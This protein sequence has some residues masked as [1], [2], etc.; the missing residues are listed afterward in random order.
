MGPGTDTSFS[1]N[2]KSLSA[3]G[4]ARANAPPL[5][6]PLRVAAAEPILRL[7]TDLVCAAIEAASDPEEVADWITSV[8]R[9]AMAGDRGALR[10]LTSMLEVRLSG[11]ELLRRALGLGQLLRACRR[12]A[13][14]A[15]APPGTKELVQAARATMSR[16]GV[17]PHAMHTPETAKELRQRT[18]KLLDALVDH[19]LQPSELAWLTE[20][21]ELEMRA[22]ALLL[23]ALAER[24]GACDGR[25]IARL[26]P[27]LSKHEERLRDTRSLLVKLPAPRELVRRTPVLLGR[28]EDKGFDSVVRELAQRPEGADAARAFVLATW[29]APLGPE[30][31]FFAG[32]VRLVADRLR[33]PIDPAHAVL[34]A[35][36]ARRDAGLALELTPPEVR[37]T[38]ALWEA[39]GAEGRSG[40]FVLEFEPARHDRLL[41]DDLIPELEA[42]GKPRPVD[43][44][45]MVLSN[46]G[47]EHVVCGLLQSPK[48]SG[49]PGLVEQIVIRT[50]SIK[51]LLEV[52]NRRDLHSGAANRNVPR[53]LLWHPG[54]VPVSAL[55]KF[56]HVRFID[57]MELASM[58]SRGSR[59]RPEVR[60]MASQYLASLNAT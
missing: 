37:A 33:V 53:A 14:G 4:A 34:L 58:A 11:I 9:G 16:A 27:V 40:E 39:L 54:G 29:R 60:Q 49:L 5:P 52:A 20:I 38:Q 26:L 21:A 44:R 6:E 24:V 13:R 47:N 8:W 1:V 31:A 56:V 57:R 10:C 50:R 19:R 48:V 12:D 18:A 35:L 32:V 25:L 22:T 59:A 36:Q 46:I 2:A 28:L 43:V 15:I 51:V 7:R 23:G 41:T 45:R 30:L 17:D 3:W 42:P 55:R